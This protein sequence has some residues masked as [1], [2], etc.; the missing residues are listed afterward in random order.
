MPLHQTAQPIVF[1]A[2][3]NSPYPKADAAPPVLRS[4]AAPVT[5]V[6]QVETATAAGTASATGTAIVTVT[7][8]LFTAPV[9]VD[10]AVTNGDTATVVGGKI[11]SALIANDQV[12]TNFVVSGSTTG[13][14]LTP[15]KNAANDATLNIAI[16]TGTA[17]GVTA[18]ATST[19]TTAGVLGTE[20]I[21]GQDVHVINAAGVFSAVY[22]LVDDQPPTWR[23]ISFGS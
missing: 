10:I 20:G 4:T 2:P 14:V 16:A 11:R 8:N 19:N 17:T 18:A 13:V 15:R 5:G 22:K 21:I 1:G 9:A 3:G 12:N 6:N 7:S 23:A